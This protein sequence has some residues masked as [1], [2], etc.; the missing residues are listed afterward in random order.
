LRNRHET[1]SGGFTVD[2]G[3]NGRIVVFCGKKSSEIDEKGQV[4]VWTAVDAKTRLLITFFAGDRTE[5]SCQAFMK[6]L[7]DA[8][9]G[10]RKPLFT[11][12]ELASYA[13]ALMEA[14]GEVITPESTGK[15]GRRQL[16]YVVPGK[17]LDYATVHKTRQKGRV[18]KVEKKVIFGKEHS[19]EKKLLDSPSTQINTSYVERLNGTLRQMDAHLSRKS[20]TFA[21]SFRYFKA[22][23]SFVAAFYDFVRPHSTLS[24]NDT[25]PSSPRTPFME[26]GLTDHPWTLEELLTSHSVQ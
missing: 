12:D 24:K 5:K 8:I 17:D 23:L 3:A 9:G 18:V 19:V 4:W 7:A 21:K 10:K 1:D 16:P 20:L 11:S 26:I 13:A 6:Q 22:K 14:F 15:R 2:R 25:R